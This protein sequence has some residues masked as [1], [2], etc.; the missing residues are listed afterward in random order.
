VEQEGK[1]YAK[2]RE[3]QK[4]KKNWYYKLPYAGIWVDHTL[5]DLFSQKINTML[6][7]KR[8]ENNIIQIHRCKRCTRSTGGSVLRYSLEKM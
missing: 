8:G 1:E 4:D 5:A 3:K 7:H 6:L 2:A